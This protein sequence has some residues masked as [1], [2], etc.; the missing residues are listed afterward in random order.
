M[1]NLKNKIS[2]PNTYTLRTIDILYPFKKWLDNIEIKNSST[3]HFI[4]QMIPSQCPFA[5]EIKVYDLTL[6]TIPPLCKLNPFYNNLM[7]LKFRSLTYLA[8]ICGEDI[9]PYC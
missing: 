5:K 1:N 7:S 6:I 9:S 4:C 3:A 2:R 8:E